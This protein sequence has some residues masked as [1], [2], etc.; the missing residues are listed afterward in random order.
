MTTQLACVSVSELSS[1]PSY[2]GDD[3]DDQFWVLHVG[4][5]FRYVIPSFDVLAVE[6]RR[7]RVGG[8]RN[9]AGQVYDIFIRGNDVSLT[10]KVY[11]A[12]MTAKDYMNIEVG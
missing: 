9:G 4:P 5:S 8:D 1:R 10:N 3:D 6:L 7:I 12:L 2:V 11:P